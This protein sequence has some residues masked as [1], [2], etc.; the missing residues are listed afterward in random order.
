M[1]H[2][3]RVIKGTV[4]VETVLRFTAYGLGQARNLVVLGFAMHQVVTGG[5]TIGDF[6]AFQAYVNLYEDGFKTVAD[7]WINFKQTIPSTGKFV[8]LLLRVPGISLSGGR[9]PQACHG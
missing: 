9:Q 4:Y 7:M 6:T 3:L 2:Y 5:M 8:Q 1:N